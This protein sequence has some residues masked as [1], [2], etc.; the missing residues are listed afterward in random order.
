MMSFTTNRHQATTIQSPKSQDSHWTPKAVLIALI[1]VI[2]SH[3]ILQQLKCAK[4]VVLEEFNQLSVELEFP[5]Y[6][7]RLLVV[8]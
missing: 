8:V 7:S 2:A 4:I 3:K 5:C 1:T 6:V